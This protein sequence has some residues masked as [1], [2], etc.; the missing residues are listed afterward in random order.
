MLQTNSPFSVRTIEFNPCTRMTRPDNELLESTESSTWKPLSSLSAL[1]PRIV[2]FRVNFPL[3][4]T[5][6]DCTISS[7]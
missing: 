1:V 5:L 3:P 4:L 6:S 7:N 2:L